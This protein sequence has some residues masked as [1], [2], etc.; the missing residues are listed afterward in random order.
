MIM[1]FLF[2]GTAH[3]GQAPAGTIDKVRQYIAADQFAAA[4]DLLA[5]DFQRLAESQDTL[6]QLRQDLTLF[7]GVEDVCLYSALIAYV[8]GTPQDAY[9]YVGAATGLLDVGWQESWHARFGQFR[10]ES[11]EL[12]SGKSDSLKARLYHMIGDVC[13]ALKDQNDGKMYLEKS[14]TL[15][16]R[17]VAA[18]LDLARVLRNMGELD[19]SKK[20]FQNALALNPRDPKA[21]SDAAVVFNA[22]GD[23]VK[24]LELIDESVRIDPDDIRTRINR[25]LFLYING[26]SAEAERFGAETIRRFPRDSVYLK[27]LSLYALLDQHKYREAHSIVN[28]LS[29]SD[30][31]KNAVFAALGAVTY[32]NNGEREQAAAIVQRLVVEQPACRE[33]GFLRN[34][35]WFTRDILK[36]FKGLLP[37]HSGTRK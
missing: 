21:L 2:A 16:P 27:R 33:D 7:T 32:A 4:G 30:L 15:D 6:T 31:Q 12:F 34:T 8:Q 18:V 1:L 24:A 35:W 23:S 10:R 29:P 14:C 9:R 5:K 3:A 11:E 22:M 25:M 28:G 13:I 19:A 26:R 36:T 17:N 37:R 20:E